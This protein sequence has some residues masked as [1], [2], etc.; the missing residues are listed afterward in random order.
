MSQL[1]RVYF[2][3][4][5]S[6]E[7]GVFQEND[8]KIKVLK[9]VIKIRILELL[10]MGLEWVILSGNLGVEQW[11]SE[12][13]VEMKNDFP[14]LKVGVIFP[15]E[16]FGANWNEKNQLKLSEM[17]QQADYV[18]AVSHQPYQNPQQLRNHT[19]FLLQHTDGS[20]LLYDEEF[21]GKTSFF[22]KDAKHF[23]EKNDY[24]IVTISMDDLQNY[25]EY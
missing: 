16:E 7:V 20:L 10:D 6:F 9:K 23:Q 3:G 15:F 4:Y 25:A 22:L 5:R 19:Q 21:P 1:R 11:V 17:K 2:T 12:V 13:I 18:N 24:Q 14:E 8:P